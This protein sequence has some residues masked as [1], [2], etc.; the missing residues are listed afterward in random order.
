MCTNVENKKVLAT[1]ILASRVNDLFDH[2]AAIAQTFQSGTSKF[3]FE[4]SPSPKKA[5][6]YF[7]GAL[8]TE[9]PAILILAAADGSKAIVLSIFKYNPV[10]VPMNS[11]WHSTTANCVISDKKIAV[12]S[13]YK[14]QG[15]FAK[16]HHSKYQLSQRE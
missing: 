13:A 4:R 1:K 16:C 2:L 10:K 7:T 8:L 11:M 15:S 3:N 9:T 6:K 14:E 12:S 5:P